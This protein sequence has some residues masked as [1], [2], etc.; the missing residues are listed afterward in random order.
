MSGAFRRSGAHERD[1]GPERQS[2]TEHEA[3]SEGP[4]T[5]LRAG[6]EARGLSPEEVADALRLQVAIVYSVEKNDFQSLP[7]PV[8]AQGYV[9][10]YAR[11]LGMDAEPLVRDCNRALRHPPMPLRFRGA[12]Q[13]RLKDIPHK[14]PG[15]VFGGAVLALALA[16]TGVLWWAWPQEAA[17]TSAT[18]AQG[19]GAPPANGAAARAD[20]PADARSAAGPALAQPP[21]APAAGGAAL[22]GTAPQRSL[23]FAFSEDCWV[24]VF[25]RHEQA[26]H[27]KLN[28]AGESLLLHGE[29][30]FRIKLGNARGVALEYDG[31]PVALAPHTRNQLASLVLE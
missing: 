15:W 10:A 14:R 7:A 9:R 26:I 5:A 19:N 11:F 18:G 31:Q 13:A 20:A 28:R 4:G 22:T 27:L 8:Y 25:D 2:R 12:G 17:A 23:A 6:R 3:C 16:A 21:R 30:P 24:E 1:S 29:A